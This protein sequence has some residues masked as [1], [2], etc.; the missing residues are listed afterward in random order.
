MRSI[1]YEPHNQAIRRFD[2]LL[3]GRREPL[4]RVGYRF[5]AEETHLSS[6]LI[7]LNDG[8]KHAFEGYS[9]PAR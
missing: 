6:V 2:E 5:Y 3:R 4:L 1:L 9:P 8:L 7:A